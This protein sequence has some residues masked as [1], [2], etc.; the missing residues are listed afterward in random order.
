M[1]RK[2]KT[3]TDLIVSA[4][5]AAA[6]ARRKAAPRTRA[7]RATDS[8]DAVSTPAVEPDAA[9]VVAVEIAVEEVTAAPSREEIAALAYSFWEARGCQ[10]GSPEE[11]WLRAE[12]ELRTRAVYATA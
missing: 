6:P 5:G 9:A 3:E 4:T 7:Q 10:G 8:V 12:E 1:T 11:D 2:R